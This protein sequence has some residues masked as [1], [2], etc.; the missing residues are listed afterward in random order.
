LKRRFGLFVVE[1]GKGA[2]QRRGQTYKMK[3]ESI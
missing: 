2:F 1:V 3:L